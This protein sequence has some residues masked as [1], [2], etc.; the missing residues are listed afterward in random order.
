MTWELQHLN[1]SHFLCDTI[2]GPHLIKI[3]HMSYM[4][5]TADPDSVPSVLFPW[6]THI[7]L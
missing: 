5:G 2:I 7:L 4:S 6:L 3:L 1:N